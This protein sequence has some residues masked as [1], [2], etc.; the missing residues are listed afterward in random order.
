ML[1]LFIFVGSIATLPLLAADDPLV[2][3]TDR[4][5]AFFPSETASL[6]LKL[7]E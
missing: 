1:G 5:L 3:Y 2:G 4:G 6:T 7:S